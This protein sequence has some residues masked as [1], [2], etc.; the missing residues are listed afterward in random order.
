MLIA[1]Y[2]YRYRTFRLVSQTVWYSQEKVV[3]NDSSIFVLDIV[4]KEDM[5]NE[6]K[7]NDTGIYTKIFTIILRRD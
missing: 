3:V 7:Q 4:S 1:L 5:T 6:Y 2:Y